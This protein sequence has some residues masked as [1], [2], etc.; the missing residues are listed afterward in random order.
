MLGNLGLMKDA[1]KFLAKQ[2][3]LDKMEKIIEYVEGE[4]ELDLDVKEM[5]GDIRLL[6]SIAHPPRDFKICDDCKCKIVI[7]ENI[8][9]RKI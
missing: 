4:N 6:K 5:K 1:A 3:K 7:T 9:E 2:F 8:E